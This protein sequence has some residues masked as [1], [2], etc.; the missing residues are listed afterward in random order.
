MIP[1]W[2]YPGAG[3]GG[4]GGGGKKALAPFPRFAGRQHSPFVAVR[5]GPLE[6]EKG[7]GG[8][9]RKEERKNGEPKRAARPMSAVR[10]RADQAA[11]NFAFLRW[12]PGP[13]SVPALAPDSG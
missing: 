5:A 7:E 6:R 4:R 11:A 8:R 9:G 2:L 3:G 13:R 10:G 12:L 1:R